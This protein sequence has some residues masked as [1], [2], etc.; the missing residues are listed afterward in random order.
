MDYVNGLLGFWPLN[1][2]LW[3][4][5]R[6]RRKSGFSSLLHYLLDLWELVSALLDRLWL[7]VEAVSTDLVLS[8]PKV[9][10]SFLLRMAFLYLHKSSYRQS[11]W[12]C[13]SSKPWTEHTQEVL[14]WLGALYSR[15]CWEA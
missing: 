15:R 6:G 10:R 13:E 5:G 11:L 3:Q 12:C 9:A 2:S 7:S 1:D 14:S 4:E 8:V